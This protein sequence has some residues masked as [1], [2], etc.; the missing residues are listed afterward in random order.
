MA[1]KTI[2]LWYLPCRPT[3]KRHWLRL[4]YLLEADL[5]ESLDGRVC[6]EVRWKLH[7]DARASFSQLETQPNL[8]FGNERGVFFEFLLLL[9][10]PRR[11]QSIG[12]LRIFLNQ[13][14]VKT[15]LYLRFLRV[16]SLFR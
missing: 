13:I 7:R 5:F 6:V 11:S 9:R 3:A 10:F 8:V 1:C 14:L 12:L 15:V 2:I 4:L 16:C